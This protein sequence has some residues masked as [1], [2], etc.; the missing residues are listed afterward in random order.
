MTTHAKKVD[1]FRTVSTDEREKYA[2]AAL[3]VQTI[4]GEAA[5]SAAQGEQ[6]HAVIFDRPVNMP[7]TEAAKALKT[8]LLKEGFAMEWLKRSAMLGGMEKE[9]WTLIVRW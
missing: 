9:L 7:Q 8:V 5:K 2:A 6:A 4:L 3:D 1:G